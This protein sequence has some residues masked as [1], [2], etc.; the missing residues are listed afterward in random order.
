M[1]NILLRKKGLINGYSPVYTKTL[2]LD[3]DSIIS[4]RS[5]KVITFI[6]EYRR[7][8]QHDETM[9]ESSRDK[10]LT[11]ILLAQLNGHVPS[12]RISTATSSTHPF[13]QR[14]N[15]LCVNGGH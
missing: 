11:M 13:T 3:T 7:L 8:A 15:L 6:L 4:P 5:I 12:I 10:E 9:S 14:T 1:F 2:I